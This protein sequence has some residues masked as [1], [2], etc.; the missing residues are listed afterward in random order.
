MEQAH[1]Q[2]DTSYDGIFS[3]AVRTS[4]RLGLISRT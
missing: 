4:E 2:R 1:N 3:L